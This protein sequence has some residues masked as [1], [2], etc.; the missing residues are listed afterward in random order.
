MHRITLLIASLIL[1]GAAVLRFAELA[2]YPPG[3]HYDEAAN[4]LITR[5]IA[6][7]GAD[8]FP[9]ANSYQGRESLYFYLSAP[10]FRLIGDGVFVLR[11]VSAWCNLLTVAATIGLGRAMFKGRRG[12]VVGLLAG[13]L[14]AISFHQIFMSRQAYRAVTLPLMQAL[15]LLCLWRGLNARRGDWLWLVVG[16]LFSGGALY[17][18]MAS[19]LFPVWLGIGGLA[20]LWFDR[21]R[22]RLRVRQGIIFFAALTVAAL[23]MLL[24]ALANPDI[25]FQRLTEVS[26]G[27]VQVTLWE[28][29][30]LHMEMFFIR[31]EFGNLRYNAP[32][33]P[34]FT[35][36]E[37]VLL[38]VGVGVALWR[39]SR[40][41]VRPTERTAYLL[42][43][44][45]PL[46][47]IPS[48]ISVA[49]FPP[50]HM[51][52]LGMVPLIFVLVAVGGAAL[53]DGLRTRM[54]DVSYRVAGAA[55][56]VLLL[57]GGGLVSDAYRDW[58]RRADLF[59][60]ADG[61]LVLASAWLP[62]QVDEATQVYVA[63]YHREHPTMI[64]GYDAP[65][66]W[67]GGDSLFL[68]AP[69][70]DGIAIFARS[71]PPPDAWRAFLEPLRM[72]GVPLGADGE[73]AFWAY[74]LTG[75][76]PSLLTD[77]GAVRNNLLEFN[78]M[79]ADPTAAGDTAQ[80]TTAWE[81]LQTPPYYRLRPIVSLLDDAG[82]TLTTTDLFLL[83]TD[84]WR[85]GERMLQNI[86]LE[87]PVG[88]P[89]GTYTLAVAWV[90]RDTDTYLSYSTEGGTSGG[91]LAAIGSLEV[92]RPE[93]FPAS[94][95]MAISTRDPVEMASGV[96]LLGWDFI[97]NGAI[98]PGQRLTPT[99]Y[100]QATG[101]DTD[102]EDVTFTA[103]LR[104]DNREDNTVDNG[105][106]DDGTETVLWRGKLRYAP[107]RWVD[108]E[109]VRLPV[110]WEVPRDQPNGDY[111]LVLRGTNVA[112]VLGTVS[113]DGEPRQFEPPPVETT[114]EVLYGDS[115]LLYGYTLAA[116]T[117]Q[118][119]LNLV[120][121]A[122]RP[123]NEDYTVFVHVVDAGGDIVQQ[124]DM[125][126][127]QN[128]Y[129]TSLWVAGEYITDAY[130]FEA[131]PT[132]D[133]CVRVG[134]YQQNTGQRLPINASDDI[135][136]IQFVEICLEVRTF[137]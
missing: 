83:G 53:I 123:V 137:A 4:I 40:H 118:V 133:Y 37:G 7:D 13:A 14:M 12:V 24:Y 45:A 107:L 72:P 23:P 76:V 113:I 6:F 32:G 20:L 60:Q 99:L 19:R 16:G 77:S 67:L 26:E 134:L 29:M 15:G 84:Q 25:F 105:T 64:A 52:S 97:N 33:R 132:G 74:R 111:Q 136:E 59:Y 79:Q 87:V 108:G 129:P 125:M 65:V 93:T 92:T 41:A 27:E 90:D 61:D 73:P 49:G 63:S 44:L 38:L 75:D 78:G 124:R 21:R 58:V 66:T 122:L 119:T 22:W 131:L 9:I 94:A 101:T 39:I 80:I 42:G 35:P 102:R 5:S 48:L 104:D 114:V 81:V 116:D 3:P 36:V 55:V 135:T 98:R 121:S 70:T 95:A 1:L 82:H 126:P 62:G 106:E 117:A 86:A 71:V 43:L 109:L 10:L 30:R 54:P 11:L 28:S 8:L 47:V 115:L 57:V 17:T 112:R 31:G 18:Y 2:T 110:I 128:R 120:W 100:W 127:Q 89:P 69:G 103:L 68:P 56:A 51:R 88:T 85:A 130:Q 91:I 50:S 46:M 96:R 34:Y